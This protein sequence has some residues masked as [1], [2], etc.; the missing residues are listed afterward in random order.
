MA[1]E[2]SESVEYVN[3]MS[4]VI[5]LL[6]YELIHTCNNTSALVDRKM[7]RRSKFRSAG[8]GILRD[9]TT[10]IPCRTPW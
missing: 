1:F 6:E 9:L 3:Y 10:F 4:T 8:V 7:R 2:L 5:N